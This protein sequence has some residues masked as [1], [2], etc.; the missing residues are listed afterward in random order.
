MFEKI[1]YKKPFIIGTG[2]GNDIISATLVLSDLVESGRMPDL[3]GI[4]SPGAFHLYNGA[5]EQPVNIVNKNARRYIHSKKTIEISFIDIKVPELLREQ[6]ISCEVYNLSGRHGTRRLIEGLKN[7]IEK[8]QY[9]GIIA[10]DVGGDILAR[11]KRDP[12]ILSPHMDFTT[13]YAVS[14]LP[15]P[16]V[17]L[18]FGLQTDGE[19]RPKGCEEILMELKEK[20]WILDTLY[21]DKKSKALETF[22]KVYEGVKGIRHGHTAHMTLQT[23]ESDEDINTEYKSKLR[24]IDQKWDYKFPVTLESKYFGKAFIIDLKP[25]AATRELA[26]PYKTPLE[27]YLKTKKIIDTRTEMDLL[28]SWTDNAC[29]WLGLLSPQIKSPMREEILSYGLDN[30]HRHA[31]SALLWKTDYRQSS[32]KTQ[33]IGDIVVIG[34]EKEKIDKVTREI[35]GILRK[36]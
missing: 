27:M 7:L 25:M 3:A 6:G 30:L 4:C 20:R 29:T 17:L 26:F 35:K 23:L 18:E 31:D 5:E 33:N 2:G 34:E 22:K 19:L 9:D 13:L 12:T 8:N 21:L 36:L 10:V 14:Q 24:V 1:P 16:S 32:M 15:I 11:G 28:Y